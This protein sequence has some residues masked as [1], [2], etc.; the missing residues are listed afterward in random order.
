MYRTATAL[1]LIALLAACDNEQPFDFEGEQTEEPTE[2]T[3]A[4]EEQELSGFTANGTTTA[5]PLEIANDLVNVA[6][7]PGAQTITVTGSTLDTSPLNGVYTRN[8][9]LDIPGYEA[10]SIQDDPLDRMFVA[11]VAEST[12]G[13]VEGGTIVD[14]GQFGSFFGGS[15]YR[16]NDTYTAGTGLVSYSGDYA[17]LANL[18][19]PRSVSQ[20]ILPLPADVAFDSPNAPQQPDMVVGTV[21]INADFVDNVVN[22][23]IVDRSLVGR[24]TLLD[25]VNLRPTEITAD[26]TFG[27][28]AERSTDQQQ[29][30]TYAGAFGGTQ[31]SGIAGAIEL[32]DYL[33]DVDNEQ[34]YGAF[35]LM[36]CGLPGGGDLC[37]SVNP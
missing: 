33:E 23:S 7:S 10:Y 24:G 15:F 37:A 3:P 11:L 22:G 8:T 30:G 35:V 26:G 6:Y 31:A 18:N 19:F 2:E 27:G 20:D 17:G 32:Q 1:S 5:I 13:S 36:R 25:D 28:E 4:E 29:I 14:G 21:F 12:D 16:R 9:S 34:E